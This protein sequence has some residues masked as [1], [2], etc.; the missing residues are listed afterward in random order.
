M[1]FN[2]L[3]N[4]NFAEKFKKKVNEERRI[5]AE[6]LQY[7]RE[8]ERRMLYAELGYS[9]LLS[10]AVQELKY[11][12]AAAYRRIAAMRLLR[13][14]PELSDKVQSGELNLSTVTQASTFFIQSEKQKNA[15][16]SIDEK[17]EVLKAIEGKSSR[18]AEKTLLA[19]NPD[20]KPIV[21]ERKQSR[22]NGTTQVTTSLDAELMKQLEEIQVLLKK[23]M[24]IKDL[25]QYLA[26]EQL[27][28]LRKKSQRHAK[29]ASNPKLI[30]SKTHLGQLENKVQTVSD[31]SKK[32]AESEVRPESE[33]PS[34]SEKLPHSEKSSEFKANSVSERRSVFE[35]AAG[36]ISKRRPYISVNLRRAVL[37]RSGYQCCYIDPVSKRRCEQRHQLQLEHKVPN[38]LGG[39]DDINNLEVLCPNHNRFRAVQKLGVTT[40]KKY[41]A[42]IQ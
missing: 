39:S 30:Y 4:R 40:M 6:V 28:I 21:E 17:R 25:L 32:R 1:N 37:H 31:K 27:A 33:K 26:T 29:P 36:G 8:A 18:E 42:S 15:K 13:D 14:V 5:T 2:N 11:S 20:L 3:N 35:V 34:K 10:F 7:F 16:L 9:T 38:A 22:G 41:M 24:Q 23:R 19:I 12:E